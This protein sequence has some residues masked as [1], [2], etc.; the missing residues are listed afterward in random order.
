MTNSAS[1]LHLND[2]A[3]EQLRAS[4]HGAAADEILRLRAAAESCLGFVH[5]ADRDRAFND[6]DITGDM[7]SVRLSGL[8]ALA[9]ALQPGCRQAAVDKWVAAHQNK[10]AN[11]VPSEAE[12]LLAEMK[13]M[14]PL[15]RAGAEGRL[16][17]GAA[18]ELHRRVQ[19][20]VE[21]RRK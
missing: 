15:L 10:V 12:L 17:A 20:I 3:I 7:V 19:A 5:A 2:L 14:L 9:E 11:V 4:G 13:D 6:I 8:C 1:P 18:F 16:V 21:A